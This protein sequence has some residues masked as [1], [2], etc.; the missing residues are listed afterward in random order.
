MTD[1]EK[2]KNIEIS[3]LLIGMAQCIAL[4]TISNLPNIVFYPFAVAG[5]CM[6]IWNEYV[7]KKIFNLIF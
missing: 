4:I 2:Q 1:Y 7:A 3:V 6:V 5:T